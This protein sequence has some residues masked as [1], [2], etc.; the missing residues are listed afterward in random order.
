M[1]RRLPGIIGMSLVIWLVEGGMFL[2]MLGAFG[3]PLSLFAAY[4]AMSIT[5]L[6]VLVPSSPG[7][8]GT[9]HAFCAKVLLLTGV[10]T[11]SSLAFGYA[12]VLHLLQLI[13]VTI[14]GLIALY[15]YGFNL[16]TLWGI[17]KDPPQGSSCK[18]NAPV[19][20]SL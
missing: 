14:L 9:F 2:L 3:W 18:K 15:S 1:D 5:N 20:L 13:P 16:R 10:V 4:L 6:G 17:P 8:I 12:A 7:H 19:P 11:T